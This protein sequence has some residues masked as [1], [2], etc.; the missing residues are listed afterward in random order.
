F[1]ATV[2]P[3]AV[4]TWRVAVPRADGSG[5]DDD[6]DDDDWQY[7]E[8]LVVRI[9]APGRDALH[10]AGHYEIAIACPGEE[11]VK[12]LTLHTLLKGAYTLFHDSDNRDHLLA[13]IEAAEAGTRTHR[14]H[15]LVGNLYAALQMAARDDLGRPVIYTTADGAASGV[16]SC[17]PT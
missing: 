12:P 11:R 16:F 1:V 4:V 6:T 13:Q 9:L 10:L 17:T 5:A 8:G 7:R 2:A 15:L 14:R 3:G